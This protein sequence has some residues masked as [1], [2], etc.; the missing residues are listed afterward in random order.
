MNTVAVD[1]ESFE[2]NTLR[3]QC[4]QTAIL[5][6]IAEIDK[7]AQATF[8]VCKRLVLKARSCHSEIIAL[9]A[10]V[11]LIVTLIRALRDPQPQCTVIL[12]RLH[13]QMEWMKHKLNNGGD[14]ADDT[15]LVLPEIDNMST[16]SGDSPVYT[17]TNTTTTNTTA[18]SASISLHKRRL[19]HTAPSSISLDR[20]RRLRESGDDVDVCM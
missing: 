12:K 7:Q 3:R 1:A 2:D 13:G 14:D 16:S 10:H 6:K 15:T 19:L 9:R 17:A 20:R 4:E 11:A 8:K 5:C 18:A